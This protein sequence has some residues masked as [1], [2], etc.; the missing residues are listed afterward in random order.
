MATRA[1]PPAGRS[2][3]TI[4]RKATAVEPP[5]REPADEIAA[6]AS[7]RERSRAWAA[8]M[9]ADSERLVRRAQD[10]RRRHRSVDAVFEMAERDSEVGG[11]IIAGALA[12]RLFIWLLPLALIAVAGLGIAADASSE[13]PEEQAESVG[14]EGLV[15]SS[16]ANAANSPNRWY[17]VLIGRPQRD[18]VGATRPAGVS[19]RVLGRRDHRSHDGDERAL[20]PGARRF[21]A[22]SP[23]ATR[24]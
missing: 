19:T 7:R 16:I 23:T 2:R 8:S 20:R 21:V 18:A 12:Y 24:A 4:Q 11:G 22:G 1:G 3:G 17:A 10:E 6:P 15:S 5:E 9:G 13:S 14:L